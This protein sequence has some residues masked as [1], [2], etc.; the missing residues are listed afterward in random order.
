MKARIIKSVIN[1][2]CVFTNLIED[3]PY[4]KTKYENKINLAPLD[5]PLRMI[6]IRKLI[7]S[8]PEAR[9][10]ILNGNGEKPPMIINK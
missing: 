5:N 9:H 2:V 6:K 1:N 4:L 7:L 10:V 3:L 8:I